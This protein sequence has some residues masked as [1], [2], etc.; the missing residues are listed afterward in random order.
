[1]RKR[2]ILAVLTNTLADLGPFTMLCNLLGIAAIAMASIAPGATATLVVLW[3]TLAFAV[4]VPAKVAV[5]VLRGDTS[6]TLAIGLQATARMLAAIAALILAGTDLVGIVAVCALCTVAVGEEALQRPLRLARPSVANLPGWE[7]RLPST[8]MAN[9]AVAANCVA[10]V[11]AVVAASVGAPLALTWVGAAPAFVFAAVLGYQVARYQYRYALFEKNLPKLMK[12]VAPVFAFHWHAPVGTA[13]QAEMWLPY[14][15]R[16]ELPYFVLVRTP[17][18]FNEVAKLTDAPVILRVGLDELDAVLCDSLKTV[19]YVN[20]AVRNSHMIR[21]P[22]LTHVQ[23]NHGDSDK[24]ASVSPTF[25]QY[26]K[27]FVAGQAAIDRFAHH[28]VAMRDDQFVIVGR[29]QL[30][31]VEPAKT[32]I[33]DITNP[34]VLYA[35]TWSGFYE[36]SDYSSLPAGRAIVAGLLA[37]G[38]TVIFRPHPYARRKKANAD[39]CDAVIALLAQDAAATG[40]AHLWGPPAE[41]E[42]SVFECFNRSDAMISDVSS[43]VSDYLFSAKP[44]AMTAVADPVE[45]FA[46]GFPVARAAY[47]IGVVDG[48]PVELDA[49][50]DALLGA[51]PIADVR[52]S[53]KAYYL[54]D[55]PAEHYAQRFINEARKVCGEP[56]L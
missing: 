27:D 34:T 30:E 42:L 24:I 49:A 13:Y 4:L 5:S 8:A 28:G 10:L 15:A 21:F 32:P 12:Q 19:F 39:G 1:M 47:V 18:N 38:A 43:V 20:T 37:R 56:P 16:L 3:I 9:C 35:P 11:L 23:L 2:T 45:T 14:L 36:S 44:F 22:Q 31:Y 17:A 54:S 40:R 41:T 52:R 50:L 26:D 55:A 48:E 53:L 6:R 33:G 25:R 51:D 46:D 29:P 7:V